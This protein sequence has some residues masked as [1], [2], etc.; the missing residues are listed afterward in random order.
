MA[1]QSDVPEPIAPLAREAV[2]FL[3]TPPDD[4]ETPS[5]IRACGMLLLAEGERAERLRSG[6]PWLE[7]SEIERLVPATRE[8]SF[9][10]GLWGPEEGVVDVARLLQALLSAGSRR[11]V[12]LLA[13]HRVSAI[14]VDGGRV[15]GVEA[16]GRRIATAAVVNAAGAW[17]AAV[18]QLAGATPVPL[19]ACR[20]HL[21]ATGPLSWVERDWPIVWDVSHDF[22]FRPEPPG[23][24]LSP[25]DESEQAP[26]LPVVDPGA[27]SLLASKLG[28]FMPRLGDLPLA[29]AWAGLRVLTPDGRFVI[30]R[31]PRVEGF[32]WCAGLGGHGMT[33]SAA[34]GRV[35]A[36][37]VLGRESPPAHS[38]ARFLERE[39]IAPSGA[40]R[41]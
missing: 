2:R 4:L 36:E 37:A 22:Y 10:G 1:R 15:V 31:D 24:L 9:E 39:A 17:A 12:R 7:R 34:V 8:G 35:A 33:T 21:F 29:R 3:T 6:G 20:R 28:R 25:C 40:S 5:L 41:A 13:A 18:G 19:R 26:G 32:V 38:P 11:G 23:L 14:D 16:G 27:A 30:G